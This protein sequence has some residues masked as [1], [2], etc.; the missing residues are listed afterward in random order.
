M[1]SF[2][3]NSELYIKARVRDG[4][5]LLEDVYFTA[6]YKIAKPFFNNDKEILNLVLMAASAGI[7]QGDRYEI[8]MELSPYARASLCGQ[9][10]SKVHRMNGGYASQTN[11]FILEEGAFL[12]YAPKPCIL[13]ADSSYH[14]TT[15][16]YLSSGSAFL[17]SDILACGREKSGERFQFKDF[18]NCLRVHN[19]N[20]LIYLDHQRYIPGCHELEGIGFFEGYT[21]QAT[22]GYFCDH[23]PDNLC[24]EL[25][26][27]L[28]KIKGIDFGV[29]KT[30]KYGVV[31]RILGCGGDRL[32][33]ILACIR[34][35]VYELTLPKLDKNLLFP[36]Q[37]TIAC[38]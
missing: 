20:E 5:T 29:S 22:L 19:N 28:S 17:Y 12:D 10:Y 15:D 6:P 33:K 11:T 18:R 26:A 2:S 14:A 8:K 7:M 16:C 27:I 4:M 13:F 3:K 21:H 31:V 35:K 34:N 9:S 24:D 25:Y 36:F 32:E 1:C 38:Y 30:Y 37:Y 23:L